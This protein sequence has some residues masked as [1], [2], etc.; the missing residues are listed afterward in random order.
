M[1]GRKTP[2]QAPSSRA[3]KALYRSWS[4]SYD[5]DMGRVGYVA[6]LVCALLTRQVASSVS[7]PQVLD[8]G[9]GTGLVGVELQ[10]WLPTAVVTGLDLS[11][12]MAR[13]AV[14]TAAYEKVLTPV[15]V[16]GRLPTTA[17]PVDVAVCCGVM[18][19]NH[20]GP[21]VLDRLLDAIA[22]GAFVVFSVRR[23]HSVDQSFATAVDRLVKQREV[24]LVTSLV[25]APYTDDEGADFWTLRRR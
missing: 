7:R 4:T 24:E 18:T 13:S 17:A 2:S 9:C 12:D 14:A 23:S 19:S 1:T 5:E 15:D 8:V 3:L 21:E 22:P 6:P 25:N 16:T 11:P 10:R 20:L